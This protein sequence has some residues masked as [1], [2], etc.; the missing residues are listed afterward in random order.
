MIATGERK[1]G[2]LAGGAVKK[3]TY[4]G[5]VFGKRAVYPTAVHGNTPGGLIDKKQQ[6]D[7]ASTTFGHPFDGGGYR[8]TA[9]QKK[10]PPKTTFNNV[11]AFD[12]IKQNVPEIMPHE[13]GAFFLRGKEI[14]IVKTQ[15]GANQTGK[16]S[17]TSFHPESKKFEKQA[18]PN[19]APDTTKVQ[20]KDK[21]P[22]FVSTGNMWGSGNHS[23]IK[24]R[25]NTISG[26]VGTGRWNTIKRSVL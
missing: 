10:V 20:N 14:P 25:P 21:I 3:D 19:S 1:Q 23:Y 17:D 15:G 9:T 26:A 13:R 16:K 11:H 8:S 7:P 22:S 5:S 4:Q 12:P 24:G 6:I 2:R 18:A